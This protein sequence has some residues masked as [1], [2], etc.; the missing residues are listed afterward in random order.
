MNFWLG[1]CIWGYWWG[2]ASS[3]LPSKENFVAPPP[4]KKSVRNPTPPPH[5]AKPPPGLGENLRSSRANK[6][7]PSSSREGIPC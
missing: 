3:I 4:P 5:L 6:I 1:Q 7:V 2:K